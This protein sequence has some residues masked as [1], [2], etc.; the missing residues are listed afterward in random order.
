M[1]APAPEEQDGN[2]AAIL[3][4]L[5]SLLLAGAAVTA[6]LGVLMRLA[7]MNIEALRYMLRPYGPLGLIIAPPVADSGAWTE[8]Q[9]QQHAQN[10]WFRA[11]YLVNAGQRL[12]RAY[13][14]GGI[15]E[16]VLAY[17]REQT[18]WA[19]HQQAA[20]RRMEA[21]AGVGHAM[22][23]WSTARLGWYATLDERTSRECRESHG[24]NFD[25]SRIPRIGYPGSVHPH[26]R[27]RAG[28]P[29]ATRKRVEQVLP[30]RRS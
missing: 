21:A 18:Y 5:V 29:F 26:C 9:A 15:A 25:P 23:L 1:T 19:Q 6:F 8:P 30:D 17:A 4:I 2:L 11:Q 24:R 14:S 16:L 20:Q 13:E 28:A 22:E 10:T 12:S 3:T 7:G 27:C